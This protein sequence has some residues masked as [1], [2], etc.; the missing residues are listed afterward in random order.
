MARTELE[1]EMRSMRHDAEEIAGRLDEHESEHDAELRAAARDGKRLAEALREVSAERDA[2]LRRSAEYEARVAAKEGERDGVAVR[3]ATVAA[4][5]EAVSEAAKR[6]VER[7]RRRVDSA[8]ANAKAAAAESRGLKAELD[9]A[10]CSRDA[11]VTELREERARREQ[12]ELELGSASPGTGLDRKSV[13][14]LTREAEAALA[15][16]SRAEKEAAE[17]VARLRL[18]AEGLAERMKAANVDAASRA[19]HDKLAGLVLEL[20]ATEKEVARKAE[21]NARTMAQLDESVAALALRLKEKPAQLFE[22]AEE[23]L[24]RDAARLRREESVGVAR[25]MGMKPLTLS[26]GSNRHRPWFPDVAPLSSKPRSVRPG[27]SPTDIP[28]GES[29]PAKS[30]AASAVAQYA[31]EA[32]EAAEAARARKAERERESAKSQYEYFYGGSYSADAATVFKAQPRRTQDKPPRS[33]AAPARAQASNAKPPA[34]APPKAVKI[35]IKQSGRAA[36]EAEDESRWKERLGE[37]EAENAAARL[38]L[39]SMVADSESIVRK[40]FGE[41]AD[42]PRAVPPPAPSAP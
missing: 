23:S 42:V 17:E 36:E 29:G 28:G 11:A 34:V 16:A 10:R 30:S 7:M 40:E 4:E 39:H 27:V 13:D 2:A 33:G 37:I 32:A 20:D 1:V 9:A 25:I 38:R 22:V 21:R 5:A 24:A 6:D 12:L 19:R 15:R 35:V 31:R 8:E 26:D 14:A 18:E 3:A 41:D